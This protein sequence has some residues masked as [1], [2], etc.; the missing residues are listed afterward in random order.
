VRLERI[1][2]SAIDGDAFGSRPALS[3]D[4]LWSASPKIAAAFF[5][6]EQGG[7]SWTR[8]RVGAGT[9][10]KPPTAFEIA[11]TDNPSLKPER[12]RSIDLG[13][14]HA[15]HGGAVVVDA[16]FF[17]NRYDQLIVAVGSSLQGA[18]RYQTDNIANARAR[19]LELGASWRGPNGLSARAAWTWL[20]TEVLDV[21]ELPGRAPSPYTVGS[22][23]V[24]RPKNQGSVDMLWSS[25]R[26]RVFVT[27]NGRGPVADLEPNLAS[28]IY[29]NP[30]YVTTAAG[31]SLTILP[32]FE[33]YGRITNL[34]D[35]PYEEVLGYP[36]LGRSVMVGLRIARSR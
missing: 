24:R 20:D 30:G 13:V 21:D 16:T 34:F 11:F 5:L 15:V 27:V 17:A 26:S 4:V 9:G 10:I 22:S 28:S 35:R 18:S 29:T 6:R 3:E 19:G 8:I 31:A 36:A 1:A 33:A 23:L 2:R 32:G 14:D 7:A 12:S 25:A